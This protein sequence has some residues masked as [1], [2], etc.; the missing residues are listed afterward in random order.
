MTEVMVKEDLKI[1]AEKVWELVRDFGGIRRWVGEMVQG[2]E[3][4]GEGVGA[5][6]TISLPGG[7]K[8]YEQLEAIDQEAR[9]FSYAIIRK[10]PL[11]VTD[12]LATL[13]LFESGADSCRIEWGST[14]EPAGISE[15]DVK[16]MIEG[17]Y[18][19]GIAGLK[20]ALGI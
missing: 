12:Y 1:A 16:P 20:E 11:P 9:S 2:L 18:N 8:L 15:A 7:I 4:E 17:I 5:I 6:R 13:T 14:F 19:S 10:S 3:L